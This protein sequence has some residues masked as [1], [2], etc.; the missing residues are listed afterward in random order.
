VLF[1]AVWENKLLEPD[2]AVLG[3][4]PREILE[5]GRRKQIAALGE[6]YAA[7]GIPFDKERNIA[8]QSLNAAAEF[9]FPVEE[10][11]SS[12]FK[13]LGAAWSAFWRNSDP[14]G[15]DEFDAHNMHDIKTAR[16]E[17]ARGEKGSEFLKAG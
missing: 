7:L 8:V 11:K 6:A 14:V 15:T 1:W 10:N 17:I 12:T 2:Y 3:V 5:R 16:G 9:L 13:K 4:D